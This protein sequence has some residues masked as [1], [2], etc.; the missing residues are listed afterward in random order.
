MPSKCRITVQEGLHIF[1][2]LQVLIELRS[3]MMGM[4]GRIGSVYNTIMFLHG[5][6]G[7]LL[8]FIYEVFHRHSK[9]TKILVSVLSCSKTTKEFRKC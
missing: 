9:V 4:N 5:I 6:Y 1:N 3:L 7:H 8:V 2:T